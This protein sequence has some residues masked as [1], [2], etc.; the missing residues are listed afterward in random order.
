MYFRN[1]REAVKAH[2]SS[3]PS[4]TMLDNSSFKFGLIDKQ[5]KVEYNFKFIKII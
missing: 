3:A 2:G 4:A 1:L 5:V